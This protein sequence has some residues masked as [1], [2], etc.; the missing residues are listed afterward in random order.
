MFHNFIAFVLILAVA[1]GS[2]SQG[3]FG[4]RAQAAG[5]E[6]LGASPEDEAR[7]QQEGPAP[8]GSGAPVSAVPG[9]GI[10]GNGMSGNGVSGNGVSGNGV[11]GNGVS[12]NGVSGNGVGAEMP[13]GPGELLPIPENPYEQWEGEP[14]NSEALTGLENELSRPVFEIDEMPVSERVPAADWTERASEGAVIPHAYVLAVATESGS[15][16]GIEFLTVDYRDA[17]GTDHRTYLYPGEEE[18]LLSKYGLPGPEILREGIRSVTDLAFAKES[19]TAFTEGSVREFLFEA[20]CDMSRILRVGIHY[21][22]SGDWTCQDLRLYRADRVYGRRMYGSVSADSY[23]VFEGELL[24]ESASSVRLTWSEDGSETFGTQQGDDRELIVFS[25]SARQAYDSHTGG[26]FGFRIDVADAYGA[27]LESL[28]NF[29]AGREVPVWQM[30][31]CEPLALRIRYEDIYGMQRQTTLPVT[32]NMLT[33]AFGQGISPDTCLAN[34]AGQGSRI[35]FEG[36]LPC[37]AALKE[38]AFI[39][40]ARE[41]EGACGLQQENPSERY[42]KRCELSE[43]DD[44]TITCAA[45]YEAGCVEGSLQ[46]AQLSFRFS[47]DPRFGFAA[48]GTE[49]RT[50][51][52]GENRIPDLL[53]DVPGTQLELY[54]KEERYLVTMQ[55]AQEPDAETS[56]DLYLRFGYADR[57]GNLSETPVYSVRECMDTYFGLWEGNATSEF[58]YRLGTSRGREL[59][60]VI[61]AAQVAAF[62]GMEA[63]LGAGSGADETWTMKGIRIE[64]IDYLGSRQASWDA[65]SGGAY[66]SDRTYYREYF[67]ETVLDLPSARLTARCGETT[68][69]DFPVR[70]REDE[71]RA[72]PDSMSYEEC[73][74][75]LGFGRALHSYTVSVQVAEST[76]M[77][78]DCGSSH[79]FYFQLLFESGKSGYVLAN[80]QLSADAFREGAEENFGI[81]IAGDY[82]RLT[83]LR[84]LPGRG[85]ADS[86]DRLCVDRITVTENSGGY[87]SESCIFSGIGWIGAKDCREGLTVPVSSRGESVNLLFAVSTAADTALDE[88]SPASFAGVSDSALC[89]SVVA[90][91]EYY[92]T[93]GEKKTAVT[94][95]VRAI[96]RYRSISENPGAGASSGDTAS[97]LTGMISLPDKMFRKNHTDC[98]LWRLE[99]VSSLLRISF[100]V[101]GREGLDEAL[102]W[103]VSGIGVSL[104]AAGSGERGTDGLTGLVTRPLCSSDS[105]TIPA[106]H[107]RAAA[108]ETGSFTAELTQNRIESS[109]PK[110]DTV[111]VLGYEPL[112]AGDTVDLYV[113]PSAISFGGEPA[114]GAADL[115]ADL[116]Y[117]DVYGQQ[118]RVSMEGFELAQDGQTCVRAG[119]LAPGLATLD[120]LTLRTGSDANLM[121]SVD[122]VLAMQMRARTAVRSFWFGFDGAAVSGGIAAAP[123]ST[124]RGVG[125]TQ[126]LYLQ[127]DERMQDTALGESGEIYASL[128]YRMDG[129]ER[130]VQSAEISLSSLGISRIG[131]GDLLRLPFAENFIGEISG[132]RLR[133][134]SGSEVEVL[135]AAVA[136]IR[137]DALTSEGRIADWYSFAGGISLAEGEGEIRPTGHG[138]QTSEMVYPLILEFQTA[139]AGGSESG[140][141]TPVRMT[142]AFRG[143]RGASAEERITDLRNFLTGEG[144]YFEAGSTRRAELLVAGTQDLRSLYLE[145]YDGDGAHT[146]SWTLQEVSVRA[147]EDAMPRHRLIG[148]RITEGTGR[149]ITLEDIDISVS[150]SAY[151]S[152]TR[153]TET[154]YVTNGSA[155]LDAASGSS[156][157]ISAQVSGSGSGYTVQAYRIFDDRSQTMGNANVYLSKSGS[158]YL[159]TP[160]RNTGSETLH[161]R[162]V[163]SVQGAED[164][165]AVIELYLTGE[166]SSY[167][168]GSGVSG[169][170]VSGNPGRTPGSTGGTDGPGLTPQG[171]GISP[172]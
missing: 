97:E 171:S 44:L 81:E 147:G 165:T 109:L 170:D 10:S 24:A 7:A 19:G 118:H 4:M 17:E 22:E 154:A 156:I 87:L 46:G 27:G 133:N 103:N 162:L 8:E 132:I 72:L 16:E 62:T 37:F 112:S 164:L 134:A 114:E 141:D 159:F 13:V 18:P 139:Q 137:S 142:I 15:G 61:C 96:S 92:D 88:I 84:I 63:V 1:A 123:E 86:F 83:A 90:V 58:A 77:T 82:G 49:G 124:L 59:K 73:L 31:L 26:R 40:G 3:L 36:D 138:L 113:T 158:D 5:I 52:V 146:A 9:S 129:T 12:G 38:A 94:D 56:L 48:S 115:S 106:Y 130:E 33:W 75:D 93:K 119:I 126:T 169:N 39:L 111:R 69:L 41:A 95:V 91:L 161:Y 68:V 131:A 121:M 76:E 150:A 110:S 122:H 60:F 172:G 163:V 140:C 66:E 144:A 108:G 143:E 145:P 2:C 57:E 32:L 116:I 148:E 105:R 42:E 45:L 151:N 102:N 74:G 11:S 85:E 80:E 51:G 67:G 101:R 21:G 152:Y 79:P 64:R 78:G 155:R 127:L 54:P 34:L 50:F 125:N 107:V 43:W 157:R 128:L 25:E 71:S 120:A 166:N 100:R 6:M 117:T 98:F 35:G 160:P 167:S 99:D 23:L 47:G 29:Y 28:S 55:T 153:R 14:E 89:G 70:D 65:V 53:E 104:A 30:D 168:G 149:R 136:M 135:R 20:E